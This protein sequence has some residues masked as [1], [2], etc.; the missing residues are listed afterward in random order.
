[1]TD[2]RNHHL[3][4][5]SDGTRNDV[6]KIRQGLIMDINRLNRSSVRG[7]LALSLFV[8]V[9]IPAWRGFWFLPSPETVIAY[10]GR[11][12]SA[13]MVS[14]VFL[15]YTFSAII[16]SLCRM[17]AGVE[18]RSSFRHVFFLTAF[19]LFYYFSNALENNYWAV[20]GSGMTILGV[21]SY[22]IWSYCAESISKKSEQLEF[23]TRTGRAPIEDEPL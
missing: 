22:R 5:D 18:H 21:E 11:P 12:P 1:M 10:L 19:Y 8:A 3:T 23:I 7:V 13:R 4:A 16:L 15:L 20:F 14:M 2:T 17:A 9:S 6:E